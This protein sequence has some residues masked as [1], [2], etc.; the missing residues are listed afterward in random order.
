MKTHTY[1]H[2]N[3]CSIM[4][5]CIQR[6]SQFKKW[7]PLSIISEGVIKKIYHPKVIIYEKL[8]KY[9]KIHIVIMKI[10]REQNINKFIRCVVLVCV[11]VVMYAR[12]D[13]SFDRSAIF[14]FY[15]ARFK[16]CFYTW[17]SRIVRIH[18]RKSIHFHE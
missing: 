9:M 18:I 17:L 16:S 10:P 14:S 12:C 1:K 11:C 4:L 3:T 8:K 7:F 2:I 6:A 5:K 15:L 13:L